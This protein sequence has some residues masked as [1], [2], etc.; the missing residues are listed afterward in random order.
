MASVD[1]FLVVEE[2]ANVGGGR[3]L[4]VDCVVGVG[5]VFGYDAS[6]DAGGVSGFY[7]SVVGLRGGAG[8]GGLG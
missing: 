7:I 5:V 8:N 2:L 3:A 4:A 6:V 1:E